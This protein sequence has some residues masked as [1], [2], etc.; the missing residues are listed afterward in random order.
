MIYSAE[1][2]PGTTSIIKCE[3]GYITQTY[4]AMDWMTFPMEKVE[5][6]DP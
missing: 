5:K 2:V 4:V 6:Y 1:N 3:K